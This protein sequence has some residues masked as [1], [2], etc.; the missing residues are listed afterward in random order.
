[1]RPNLWHGPDIP[2]LGELSFPAYSTMLTIGFALGIF[3]SMREAR[4]HGIDPNHQIDLVLWMVVFG[5]A[6]ARVMHVLADGHF[7]DYVHMCTDP[8]LVPAIDPPT[9]YCTSDPECGDYFLCDQAQHICHPPRDCLVALKVWRGGLA[10]Y[11]GFIFAVLYALYFIRKR[12]MPAWRT[13]DLSSTYVALGLFFGR[14]GCWLNGCCYG[15]VTDSA[16][17]VVFPRGSAVWRWQLD[18]DL[19]SR[20]D[21]ALPVYPTQL[22]QAALNLAMF[23]VLYWLVRP[24]K[25]FDGQVFAWLLILKAITRSV[26]EIWRD[27]E[28]GVFFGGLA[29]TSQ[30]LSIP[31]FALGV[32]LLT[33]PPGRATDAD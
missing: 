25:R 19:I 16:L 1:M 17:G 4:R 31:L 24:R 30:L 29:S 32:Y 2:L 28:R 3:L 6:G 12:K 15:K 5:L 8:S 21:I 27:D 22:Y 18:H 20:R 23:A 33:H 13:F 10:Y 14:V 11:G 26:V 9:A 7:M